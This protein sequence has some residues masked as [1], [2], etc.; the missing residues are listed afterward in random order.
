MFSIKVEDDLELGF[1]T[2]RTAPEVFRVVMENYNFLYRW[3]PWL[4]ENYSLEVAKEFAK[5]SLRY[6][7]NREM[8]ALRIVY[9]GETVGGTGF[10]NFNW[11]YK[12]TEIGYWLAEK[13]NG[14]GIVTKCC[15]ALLEYAFDELAL[16]R[17]V[18]KCQPENVKSRLVPERL[19]FVEEGIERQGGFHDGE[20]VDF[21]VYSMLAKEWQLSEK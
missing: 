21:V 2:E 1:Y 11:H 14:K 5:I 10:N 16:N 12:T 7:G 9:K 3:T 13:Y 6:F 4:D 15:R 8:M 19:N 17:V 20:F 18:I